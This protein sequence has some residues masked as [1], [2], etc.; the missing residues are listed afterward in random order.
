MLHQ[1]LSAP[2]L[3]AILL[4]GSVAFAQAGPGGP[5][6]PAGMPVDIAKDI[7]KDLAKD[8]VLLAL[9][10]ALAP[11][12][13]QLKSLEERVGKWRADQ[14][15]VLEDFRKEMRGGAGGPGGPGGPG[16]ERPSPEIRA[17]NEKKLAT[18]IDPLNA[19]FMKDLRASLADDTQR[20]KLV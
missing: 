19:A 18:K 9:K 11:N 17:A 3:S 12:A 13:E 16:G 10:E 1:K 20:A 2:F 6:P 7:A 15:K 5:P 8:P 4:T 14:R